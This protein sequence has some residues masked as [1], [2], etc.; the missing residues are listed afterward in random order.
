MRSK[1]GSMLL[2]GAVTLAILAAQSAAAQKSSAAASH[3]TS[4]AAGSLNVA[5][6]YNGEA[7][8]WNGSSWT[9]G[10]NIGSSWTPNKIHGCTGDEAWVPMNE[11]SIFHYRSDGGFSSVYSGSVGLESVWCDV[12][13]GVWVVGGSGTVLHDAWDDAGF[14]LFDAGTD[15]RLYAVWVSDAGD[16]WFAGQQRTL[17]RYRTWGGGERTAYNVQPFGLGAYTDV[18]GVGDELWVSGLYSLAAGDG[19]VMV[20]YKV[21]P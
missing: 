8:E 13:S 4:A 12:W 6:T 17:L 18:H 19:G 11:G 5:V 16:V 1:F 20:Q 21:G 3:A 7:L 14:Q 9:L 10:P 2:A 15:V